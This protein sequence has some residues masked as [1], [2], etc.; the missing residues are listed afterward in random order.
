MVSNTDCGGCHFYLAFR[1]LV[2]GRYPTLAT[3]QVWLWTFST[4]N[5]AIEGSEV[6]WKRARDDYLCAPVVWPFIVFSRQE[7]P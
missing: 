6:E 3:R 2:R 7:P 4:R 1:A 5:V